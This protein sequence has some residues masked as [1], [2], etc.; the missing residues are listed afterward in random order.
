MSKM[1]KQDEEILKY[2]KDNPVD[3][4]DTLNLGML[5]AILENLLKDLH[6]D[7]GATAEEKAAV[8]EKLQ[9][10][11]SIFFKAF[12]SPEAAY[13]TYIRHAEFAINLMKAVEEEHNTGG[14]NPIALSTGLK[15][16]VRLLTSSSKDFGNADSILQALDEGIKEARTHILPLIMMRDITS[17]KPRGAN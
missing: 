7:M 11:N 15:Y 6:K 14:L 5:D 3:Q 8:L 9:P 13:A 2:Y 16:F 4:M 1:N 17:R 12:S 10:A